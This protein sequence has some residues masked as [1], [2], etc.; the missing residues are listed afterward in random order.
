MN[1]QTSYKKGFLIYSLILFLVMLDSLRVCFIFS[2]SGSFLTSAILFVLSLVA[3]ISYPSLF[4]FRK[5]DVLLIIFLFLI[6]RFSATRGNLNAYFGMIVFSLNVIIF[7]GLKQK[8]KREFLNIFSK[9]FA[10]VLTVS[11]FFWILYLLGL[12]LPHQEIEYGFSENRNE[13]QYFFDNYYFFLKNNGHSY[14][15]L[16]DLILPRF[17]SILLEPGYLGNILVILLIVNSFNLRKWYNIVFLLSL[18][19]T[20]S[21]SGW[22]LFIFS[23]VA[24]II[25]KKKNKRFIKFSLTIIAFISLYLFFRNYNSG[26]NAVN[27]MILSRLEYDASKGSLAGYNRTTEQFD[28]WYYNNFLQGSDYLFGT[29]VEKY[30]GQTPNVGWKMYTAHFGFVALALYF[31]FLYFPLS[32]AKTFSNYILFGTYILIFTRGHHEIF[33]AA[34]PVLYLAGLQFPQGHDKKNI[35]ETV[36]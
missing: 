7:F 12:N 4:S 9:W 2:F 18:I 20:F 25:E 24:F 19:F 29:D 3:L 32:R 16:S 26:N 15:D 31:L 6:A 34:F 1:K 33:W 28:D 5:R 22:M 8:Y 10:V 27:E 23:I 21:L 14:T 35:M 13:A 30:F 36:Q 17:S 11:L